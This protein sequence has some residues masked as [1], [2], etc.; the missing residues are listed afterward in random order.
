MKLWILS[1]TDCVDY[2]EYDSLVV[3]AKDESE[4]RKL[5]QDYTSIVDC[6][7][8]RPKIRWD[9]SKIVDCKQISLRTR[10]AGVLLGSY[11]AG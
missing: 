5:A 11:N 6:D 4:A 7:P 8:L 1:R 10:K 2:D 9:N 3:L